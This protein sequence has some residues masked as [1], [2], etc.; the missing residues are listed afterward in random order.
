MT[1]LHTKMSTAGLDLIQMLQERHESCLNKE[2]TPCSSEMGEGRD[3]CAS[4]GLTLAPWWI[5]RSLSPVRWAIPISISNHTQVRSYFDLPIIIYSLLTIL[6]GI[7]KFFYFILTFNSPYELLVLV[8]LIHDGRLYAFC[9]HPQP[10]YDQPCF[11]NIGF[12]NFMNV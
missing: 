12:V 3:G 7:A 6:P 2:R 8:W 10:L 11:L 1:T 5:S 9:L 4:L